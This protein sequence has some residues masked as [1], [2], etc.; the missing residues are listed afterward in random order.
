VGVTAVLSREPAANGATAAAPPR[1]TELWTPTPGESGGADTAVVTR[2]GAEVAAL[3]ITVPDALPVRAIR[4]WRLHQS[5]E[6]EWIDA[7]R[8]DEQAQP[9]APLLVRLPLLDGLEPVPWEAGQYRVDLLVGDGIHR[10]SVVIAQQFGDPPGPDDWPTSLPDTVEA[11]ASDPSGVQF[12]LF[13]T[14]DG[15]GVSIPS[16]E[17]EPLDE[18]QAWDDAAVVA[19]YLPRATGLGVMLTSH[20]RSGPRPCTGSRLSLRGRGRDGRD[21]NL[22]PDSLRHPGTRRRCVDARRV[23]GH[24]RLEGCCRRASRDLARGAATRRRLSPGRAPSAILRACP[25]H[26]PARCHWRSST[27]TWAER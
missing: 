2:A 12:G 16:R 26:S 20:A 10:I 15:T 3:G 13:A 17:T 6:L 27:V 24:G 5:N 8:I 9:A 11:T 25:D 23:R 22:R 18:A 14:V 4:L 1:S 21:P 19:A 7:T